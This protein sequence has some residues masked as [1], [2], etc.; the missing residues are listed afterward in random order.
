MAPSFLGSVL[1]LLALLGA[2]FY[3]RRRAPLV[4][5]GIAWFLVTLVPVVQIIP[6][7]E[8]AAEHHLYLASVGFC[9]ALGVLFE[10]VATHPVARFA[11]VAMLLLL[12][13]RAAARNRD[14]KDS[15]T[16]WAVTARDAP[17]CARAQY[18]TGFLKA[19][20]GNYEA[21]LPP[22]RTA[23]QIRGTSQDL[24]ALGS[25][26]L[27]LGREEEAV[28]ELERALSAAR[29][30]KIPAVRAG[31]ILMA[32]GRP[33]DAIPAFDRDLRDRPWDPRPLFQKG[34]CY[35]MV[36][37]T[38]A[39]LREYERMLAQMPGDYGTLLRAA[40]VVEQRGD[41]GRARALRAR[42]QECAPLGP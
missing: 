38:A 40:D 32:L 7:H 21:A 4:A 1:V 13:L 12:A 26:L 11:G 6:F 33:M 10:R 9:L 5:F 35:E 37:D 30:E 24:Y 8:L 34:L 15:E 39:A 23:V 22:L 18:N 28:R 41:P 14:W 19:V 31:T 17:R 42:A 36:G 2:V 16:L 29:K 25:T 3:L 20:R 27:A